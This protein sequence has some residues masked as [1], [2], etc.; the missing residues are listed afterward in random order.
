[1]K[2]DASFKNSPSS[3]EFDG[4]DEINKSISLDSA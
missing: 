2:H 4:S 3:W 1:M